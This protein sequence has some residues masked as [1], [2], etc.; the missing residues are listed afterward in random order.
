MM[1]DPN[2]ITPSTQS[3]PD[4]KTQS[5]KGLREFFQDR[6]I[7]NLVSV[8]VPGA[9]AAALFPVFGPA[10]AGVAAGVAIKNGLNMLGISFSDHTINEL[11]KP[12]EGKQLDENDVQDLLQETL[13][14]LLPKDKQVNEEAA[15][16]L[17]TVVPDIKDA[18]KA[19]TK[20]DEVWLAQSLESNLQEQGEMMATIA[21]RVRNLIQLNDVE[22]LKARDQLLNDWSR[23]RQEVSATDY[24][25]V[26]GVQQHAKGDMK[27][28]SQIVSAS[29]HSEVS[30]VDQDYQQG[31]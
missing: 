17:V 27:D 20:I 22:L 2:S 18:A 8:L 29:G 10:I 7:K 6:R 21:P 24:G 9:L 15:K 19:N 30:Q 26:K 11:V 16:A 25:K 31:K 13:T 3:R 23:L 14:E 4:F 1:N 5:K 12:L 28:V